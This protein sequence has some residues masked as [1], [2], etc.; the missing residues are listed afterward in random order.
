MGNFVVFRESQHGL[1]KIPWTE[2]LKKKRFQNLFQSARTIRWLHKC[3]TKTN[4]WLKNVLLSWR[5]SVILGLV[6]N[7]LGI[8]PRPF[9]NFPLAEF[10]FFLFS[11][12]DVMFSLNVI[13]KGGIP[14]L[15]QT[16]LSGTFQL[17][18]VDHASLFWQFLCVCVGGWHQFLLKHVPGLQSRSSLPLIA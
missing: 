8:T 4:V 6:R 16:W 5:H 2:E 15:G 18:L 1:D 9:L 12:L 14:L 7:C 10:F 3:S 17:F 11:D 13:L